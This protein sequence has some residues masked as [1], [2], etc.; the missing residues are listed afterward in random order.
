MT[1]YDKHRPET[2]QT[3]FGS[4]AKS[5][6][7][8]NA[9]L[10]FQLHRL[11]NRKLVQATIQQNSKAESYILADL[12]CGTGA[13]SLPWLK[14]QKMS[15][16]A[17]LIDFCPEMLACAKE[18]A[19]GLK[20]DRVHTLSYINADVQAMPL[21]SNSVDYATM[22]YG[23]RNVESP[24]KCFQEVHR[25]LKKHGSFG[26]LELT[27]PENSILRLGHRLYLKTALP[28]LGKLFAKN[29]EAYQYLSQSIQAFVKPLELKLLLEQAGFSSVQVR[30][31][32]LGIAT[33]LIAHK[34]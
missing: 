33:L 21:Q 26:I 6:D 27:E 9:I 15:Q 3:M 7:R 13:I 29:G 30:P 23:I 31:I 17:F 10:S 20:L 22:A 28:L 16:K 18:K 5:Y 2:I 4:I 12:C 1:Q 24:A 14:S 11:W 25:I 19:D 8:T 32:S 34:S